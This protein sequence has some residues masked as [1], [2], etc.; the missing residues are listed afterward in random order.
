MSEALKRAAQAIVVWG[1]T[2]AALLV[3]WA[4]V[5]RFRQLWILVGISLLAN[6]FQPSYRPFEGSRTTE[7]RGTA[8]QILW[9]VYLSQ[10]AAIIELVVKKPANLPFDPISGAAFGLMIAG[11]ALRT[12]SFLVLGRFFTWN[13]E[14]QPDQKLIQSG[15]YRLIRHPSYT[16]ALL[17]FLASICLLRSWVA[18]TLSAIALP[19]AFWRRIRHEERLL[20]ETF[21]EHEQY[22]RRTGA[23]APRILTDQK[24]HIT[25]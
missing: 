16:G 23:L 9:T 11:L 3:V 13:V 8:V 7:D 21:P 25:C 4:P 12:W 18:A 6:V 20:R 17:T 22:A 19:F 1:I 5:L 2:A 24:L 14:V 15:P 10:V